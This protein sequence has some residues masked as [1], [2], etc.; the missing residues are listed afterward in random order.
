LRGTIHQP[1]F[2]P[3]LLGRLKVF[4]KGGNQRDGMATAAILFAVE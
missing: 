2:S 1:N 3:A 4:L